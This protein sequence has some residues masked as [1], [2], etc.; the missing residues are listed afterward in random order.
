MTCLCVVVGLV[1]RH[2]LVAW[3]MVAPYCVVETRCGQGALELALQ[4]NDGVYPMH[5]LHLM[6]QTWK[7]SVPCYCLW[8]I[9]PPRVCLAL[10][11]G[12]ILGYSM[13]LGHGWSDRIGARTKIQGQAE[14]HICVCVWCGMVC[15]WCVCV[16]W[17]AV[18]V[19]YTY[20]LAASYVLFT[21]LTHNIWEFCTKTHFRQLLL[22]I[23]SLL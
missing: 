14:K 23:N 3:L 7:S 1:T 18:R 19:W 12:L 6:E 16:V 9:H 5:T 10:T 20:Q 11:K 17:C 8:L 4:A 21:P 13:F 2:F 22:A 15:V